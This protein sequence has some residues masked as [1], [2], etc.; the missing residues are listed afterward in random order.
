MNPTPPWRGVRAAAR[1]WVSCQEDVTQTT[2]IFRTD[3]LSCGI[4]LVNAVNR[5]RVTGRYGERWVNH[6]CGC[7]QRGPKRR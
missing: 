6:L 3:A 2:Y 5:R 4:D 7:L 1:L